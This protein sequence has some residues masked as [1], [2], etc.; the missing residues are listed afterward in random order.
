MDVKGLK[1]KKDYVEKL[2]EVLDS[3][4]NGDGPKDPV[5]APPSG[6]VV[7]PSSTTATQ[8]DQ[9]KHVSS[10]EH[11][12]AIQDPETALPSDP[13]SDAPPIE[14]EIQDIQQAQEEPTTAITKEEKDE[15]ILGDADGDL[16][17]KMEAAAK[18]G[19]EERLEEQSGAPNPTEP[20]RQPAED[21]KEEGNVAVTAAEALP[22]QVVSQ[23][24]QPPI[25]T[26]GEADADME[27][28]STIAEKRKRTDEDDGQ[29]GKRARLSPSVQQETSEPHPEPATNEELE[30]S[31][32]TEDTAEATHPL[33]E[34]LS[35]VSHPATRA[36]YI[37]N[38][39]R[40]LLTPD[41]K[42]WLIEQGVSDGVTDDDVLDGEA[43]VPAGVWLD[44]VKSH[45][46]CIVSGP[47]AL[48]DGIVNAH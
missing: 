38:L 36:L 25:A 31:K 12:E 1:L 6:E 44:G 10:V 47:V 22:P 39:K 45:C 13:T 40:P 27:E 42:A 3:G 21:V 18:A 46:Y 15:Q 33:P 19:E 23:V 2:H 5:N 30:S 41:L 14:S 16:G 17:E 28:E 26:E 24:D 35:H 32:Q 11:A 34:N 37:S 8:D 9:G 43:G 7:D 20:M 4:S 48:Q 29:E